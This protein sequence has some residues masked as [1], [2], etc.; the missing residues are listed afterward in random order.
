MFKHLKWIAACLT[1]LFLGGCV[2]D[3]RETRVSKEVIDLPGIESE[4]HILFLTDTHVISSTKEQPE[5]EYEGIWERKEQFVNEA[6]VSSADQF[7][8][9]IK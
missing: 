2:D 3:S 5:E 7:S 6:G 4:Y 1:I 8:Q 9:W